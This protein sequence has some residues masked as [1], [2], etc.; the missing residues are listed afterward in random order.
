MPPTD[1]IA[2]LFA[3]LGKTA[4]TAAPK[5]KPAA[6]A[7]A[8]ALP[9]GVTVP[10]P[11]KPAAPPA[12]K[13]APAPP[14]TKPVSVG[15]TPQSKLS[16]V[17]DYEQDAVNWYAQLFWAGKEKQLPAEIKAAFLKDDYTK[18]LSG[19]FQ[20][21]VLDAIDKGMPK[22]KHP[23]VE[24]PGQSQ[25]TAE[26]AKT[27]IKAFEK[28]PKPAPPPTAT[29]K[30]RQ[31][32]RVKMRY[33]TPA[34]HGSAFSDPAQLS[35][36]S[37]PKSP[38]GKKSF[39]AAQPELSKLYDSGHLHKYWLNTDDYH[40]FNAHG[41]SWGT[42]GKK[43][44]D[45]ATKANKKG[46][47]VHNVADEPNLTMQQLGPQTTYVVFDRSSIRSDKA[48]FK[49]GSSHLKD[50]LASGAAIA[51]GGDLISD[52]AEA[53]PTRIPLYH[54]SPEVFD[55]F[56]LKPRTGEGTSAVAKG[57][58]LAE[59]PAVMEHYAKQFIADRGKAVRYE[60]SADVDP[61]LIVRMDEPFEKQSPAVQ[62]ALTDVGATD[63]DVR[64]QRMIDNMAKGKDFDP[65]V[66]FLSDEE[67]DKLR[68]AG[69]QG[70][71][72]LDARS[73]AGRQEGKPT[74][75]YTMFDPETAAITK[76]YGMSGLIAGGGAY[77]MAQPDQA[78]AAGLPAGLTVPDPPAAISRG[79]AALPPGIE[80]P[81]PPAAGG[82]KGGS[83][84]PLPGDPNSMTGF[85][86]RLGGNIKQAGEEGAQ[87]LREQRTRSELKMGGFAPG[88][89]KLDRLLE[90]TSMLG[91][92]WNVSG[93]G[94]AIT[95]AANTAGQYL[96]ERETS[97]IKEKIGE[98]YPGYKM[99]D[100]GE[101]EKETGREIGDVIQTLAPGGGLVPWAKVAPATKA[102]LTGF[103]IPGT[104]S[105]FADLIHNSKIGQLT[106]KILSPTTIDD[107][108]KIA[109]TMLRGAG[110]IA[111]RDTEKA[112][113]ILGAHQK[114]INQLPEA[115]RL[116]F[117]DHV[118][119][120]PASTASLP[121]PLQQLATAMRNEFKKVE[122]KLQA[123][124]SHAQMDF[125]EN[126]Y[127]HM[128]KDPNAAK[129]VVK[130]HY[131]GG[132]AKQGSGASLKKREIPTV[133][134]GLAKGLE[135]LT[136]DPIETTMRY[137]SSINRFIASEAV[138]EVAAS[139]GDIKYVRPKVVGASGHPDSFKVPD[140]W[141]PLHG[142]GATRADGARAYAPEG[143]AR[144]YNNF[145]SKGWHANETA[146]EVFDMLQRTGNF[147]TQLELGLSGFHA[148]TMMNEAM[149]SKLAT[150]IHD[151][152]G[153]VW[154]KD[155]RRVMRGG[156][157]VAAAP[158][159]PIA[160]AVRGHK[161]MNVYLGATGNPTMEHVVNL[162]E[163]AGGRGVG[164][165]HARDYQFS[166]MGSY[167]KAWKQGAL[168]AQL[169]ADA[170]DIKAHPALG[171]LRVGFRHLGRVMESV[172]APVFNQYIP[173]IKNGAFY[174]AMHSWLEANPTAP[175]DRQIAQARVIWDSI[176]NRFGELVNDNVFWHNTLKQTAQLAM[177]SYS[178]NLGTVRELGG[179]VKDIA[180]AKWSPRAAYVIAL[181]IQ[182]ATVNAVYQYLKTGE[183]PKSLTDLVAG[184][185]GGEQEMSI[186][187]TRPFGKSVISTAPERVSVP[188]YQKDVMGWYADA[189][190][191]AKNKLSKLATLPAELLSN[192][193]WRDNP[194]IN[195]EDSA[196]AWLKA[197][198]SH[199][200]NSLSPI[201]I[202]TA[203]KGP[204]RGSG[205]TRPEQLIGLRPAPGYI[206]NPEGYA[207]QQHAL[208]LQRQRRK[209]AI[210]RREEQRYGGQ[211]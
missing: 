67:T 201:S 128:W 38:S 131:T 24:P 53:A 44:I 203:T 102:A 205:I 95:G 69:L 120:G 207:A 208:N 3:M 96:A 42:I 124:P 122:Q 185:T 179:G 183:G 15:T 98:P 190:Q 39:L 195:P 73:R 104:G 134:D 132:A 150:G 81:S 32:S 144:V 12:P 37:E 23:N 49:P 153:G 200:V 113:A 149:V 170:A 162:L 79:A 97:R 25:M 46:I 117:I 29:E 100:Q 16:N 105:T 166:A 34:Y 70:V 163:R 152:V 160:S 157:T 91:G 196:P 112:R 188:G 11:P 35:K 41:K 9:K 206:S 137:L 85:F 126:Y 189:L 47:I 55:K 43:A 125:V 154:D 182:V 20:Q 146:G 148:A 10:S 57:V 5:V 187:S 167:Q 71:Q 77:G 7:T 204:A 174:D 136:S 51:V 88:A 171:T 75:N 133:A 106:Q 155:L 151:I 176:D 17:K 139:M 186:P 45:E 87:T 178:W 92:A 72:Y 61:D 101:A 4:P 89:S 164:M 56:A 30:E 74:Y 141:M 13:P 145:L 93:I 184:R 78:Q 82:G 156:F 177:R 129:G 192:R 2:E 159:A 65:S 173:R 6:K 198:A 26:Q 114:V 80:V 109:E 90:F 28:T 103:F 135:P 169:A 99:P 40:M 168:K 111:A 108:S 175:I 66:G 27:W 116:S 193:D 58:Y 210:E 165:M 14:A 83:V 138:R 118:E 52:K 33:T 59:N 21:K 50:L 181:P 48:E 54:A 94:T 60:V 36:Y 121:P 63:I 158:A 19:E 211:E 115:D 202:K 130:E 127:P 84:A 142:R 86:E 18:N 140:G 147:M 31:A 191:E 107:K 197:W 123:L 110:G 22:V 119:G 209:Q 172:M 76:R 62:K 64:R 199:V 194:I 1:L 180:T 8:K 161:V 143:F 68:E